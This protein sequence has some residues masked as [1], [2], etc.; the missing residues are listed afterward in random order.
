MDSLFGLNIIKLSKPSE[1][2]LTSKLNEDGGVRDFID[3]MDN[4]TTYIDK[5]GL[6]CLITFH[7]AGFGIT[8][9]Y[10]VYRCRNDNFNNA[11]TKQSMTKDL[12]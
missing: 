10:Y 9:G 3:D 6:E 1:L 8:D 4:E 12:H 2:P 11:V 7:E 5:V